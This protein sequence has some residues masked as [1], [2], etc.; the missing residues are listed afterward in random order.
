MGVIAVLVLAKAET[1]VAAA[2]LADL[3]DDAVVAT[4]GTVSAPYPRELRQAADRMRAAPEDKAAAIS[5]ARQYLEYGHRIGDARFAGAALGAIEP[6]VGKAPDARVL[7]LAASA[8]QYRHDF[9]GALDLLGKV[10]ELEPGNAQA[11]LARA[12]ILVVQ[13]KAKEAD[14]DC[15]RLVEAAQRGDLGILCNTTTKA[16]TAEAPNSYALLDGLLS[17]GMLDPALDGYGQSLL[18]EMARFQQWRDKARDKFKAAHA[19]DPGDLRT[20]MIFADFELSEGHAKAALEL[21]KDAPATDSIM[22]RQAIAAKALGDTA[23][24]AKLEQ[25]LRGR[26]EAA[27]AA[28]E[29]AHAREAARFWLE[30]EG[31]AAAALAAAQVNWAEQRELEDALLLIASASAAGKPEA[32]APVEAWAAA[33]GVAVPMYREALARAKAAK[34]P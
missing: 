23:G 21:M 30:V 13:G 10:I 26:I 11:L 27:R 34:A 24:L 25:A 32:I 16:L 17:A 31:D 6:W 15:L 9:R 28:G 20:L 7:N 3:P 33:E 8:R 2:T 29:T 19:K 5:A 4:L 22:V 14:L 1:P 18:A 12:N